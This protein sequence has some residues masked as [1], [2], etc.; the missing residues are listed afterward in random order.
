MSS[1]VHQIQGDRS[2]RLRQRTSGTQQRPGRASCVFTTW[3]RSRPGAFFLT[4]EARPCLRGELGCECELRWGGG[5]RPS[6]LGKGQGALRPWKAVS[7]QS[8]LVKRL[9]PSSLTS[10]PP[11]THRGDARHL[12][13]A[14]MRGEL[15]CWWCHGYHSGPLSARSLSCT[16]QPHSRVPHPRSRVRDHL[17]YQEGLRT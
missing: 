8:T 11:L 2:R 9:W 4:Q 5:L 16:P 12:C 13:P 17:S 14:W 10:V 3:G 7:S 15:Q 1:S 6:F